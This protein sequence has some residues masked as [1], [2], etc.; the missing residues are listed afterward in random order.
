MCGQAKNLTE[1]FSSEVLP[2]DWDDPGHGIIGW[3]PIF[4]KRGEFVTD[5]TG[6]VFWDDD[7]EQRQAEIPPSPFELAQYPG[8]FEFTPMEISHWRYAPEPPPEFQ[9]YNSGELSRQEGG[10]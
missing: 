2:N 10:L 7:E 1:W 6:P 8:V 3:M 5:W 4:D 9:L